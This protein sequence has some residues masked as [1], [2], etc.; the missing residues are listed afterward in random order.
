MRAQVLKVNGEGRDHVAPGDFDVVLF[1]GARLRLS[2]FFADYLQWMSARA[3]PPSR[4]ALETAARDYMISARSYRFAQAFAAAGDP[5]LFVPAPFASDGVKDFSIK[6]TLYHHVPRA[7]AAGAAE[8]GHLWSVFEAVAQADGIC[9]MRQPDHT[10]TKGILT[11]AAYQCEGAV[12][13]GD[14]GHKSPAFAA[15]WMA[16]VWPRLCARPVAA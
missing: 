4:A 9:L 12:A 5:V 8:R 13:D 3:A 6:G 16:E 11:R 15:L 1:Y 2:T 7:F 10:V 14:L